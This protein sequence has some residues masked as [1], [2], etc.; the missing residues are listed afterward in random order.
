MSVFYFTCIGCGVL[1]ASRYPSANRCKVCAPKGSYVVRR[2]RPMQCK[3]CGVTFVGKWKRLCLP[4]SES[5]ARAFRHRNK[6]KRNALA[7]GRP[8][9]AADI[10]ERDGW[11]CHL[12]G[13]AC[14]RKAKVPHNKAATIDHL[15][16]VSD[17]GLDDPLNVATAHFICNSK[18][19]AGGVAQLRLV[20]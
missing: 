17:G 12:C 20:A 8:F 5:N 14:D 13:K 4:C 15:I 10:F 1:K 18:R 9:S 11:R 7:R 3:Q 19:G 16:P 2:E 6:A